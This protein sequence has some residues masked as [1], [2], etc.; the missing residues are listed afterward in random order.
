THRTLPGLSSGRSSAKPQGFLYRGSAGAIFLPCKQAYPCSI[1]GRVRMRETRAPLSVIHEQRES[2]A[3][4]RTRVLGDASRMRQAPVRR[5]LEA[6]ALLLGAFLLADCSGTQSII[7]PRYGVAASPRVVEPG[8]PVP[9][10]G[11]AYRIGQP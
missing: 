7:D 3:C 1:G 4:R 10:G 5:G 8:Q 9:K 2:P 11:G 6:S